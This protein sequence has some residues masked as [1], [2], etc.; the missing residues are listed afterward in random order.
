[1]ELE[2]LELLA[3]IAKMYFEDGLTQ[4]QISLRSGYSRSMVSRFLSEARE[5]KIVEITINYPLERNEALETELVK[6]YN[7]KVARVLARR[8]LSYDQMVRRLGILAARFLDELVGPGMTIGVSW[9][10]ALNEMINSVS[11]KSYLDIHVVQLNGAAGTEPDFDSPWLVQKLAR[12]Y[13]GRYG[14]LSAP[15]IVDSESTRDSLLKDKLIQGM[16]MSAEDMDIALVGIGTLDAEFSSLTRSGYLSKEESMGLE[17]AGAVGYVCALF[18]DIY[19]NLLDHPITQRVIG[20]SPKTLIAAPIRLGVAGGHQKILPVLG[21]LRGGFLNVLVTDDVVA[22]E[23][24]KQAEKDA[25]L[26]SRKY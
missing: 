12:S 18:Y 5:N 10:M 25:L 4:D 2:R 24:V 17:K 16:L 8:T 14:I 13:G 19:G 22:S 21:A 15:L 9:G 26:T 20:V 1:M 11:S 7:L 23:L 6:H 3:S